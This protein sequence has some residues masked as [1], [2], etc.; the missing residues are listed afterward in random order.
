MPSKGE[1][2]GLLADR[3]DRLRGALAAL[4]RSVRDR[5]AEV[6]GAAVADAVRD[7]VRIAPD[8]PDSLAPS[9]DTVP[10]ARRGTYD[11]WGRAR[12]RRLGRRGRPDR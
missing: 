9:A 8:P 2:A 5:V 12:T 1:P 10:L 6:V 7:T 3:I 11:P 4:R